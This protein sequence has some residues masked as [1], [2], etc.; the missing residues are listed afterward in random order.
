LEPVSWIEEGILFNNAG[1]PIAFLDN[2]GVL[3][4]ENGD[5][6]G[7]FDKGVFHDRLGCAVAFMQGVSPFDL[8]PQPHEDR[9]PPA[10]QSTAVPGR[11][12]LPATSPPLVKS[13]QMQSS[14]SWDQFLR[15]SK[16]EWK[17]RR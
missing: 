10:V 15:G 2:G 4:T 17:T 14:L 16:A 3:A 8:L 1:F 9:T 6:L 13:L 5:Y 12:N 11:A 7:Q